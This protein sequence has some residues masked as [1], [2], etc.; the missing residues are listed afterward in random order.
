MEKEM[1]SEENEPRINLLDLSDDVLL[2]ILSNLNSNDLCSLSRTCSRLQRITADKSLWIDV[3]Y[4]LSQSMPPFL[5]LFENL[6]LL[7]NNTRTI[8]LAGKKR[9]RKVPGAFREVYTLTSSSSSEDEEE[10]YVELKFDL[11]I[12]EKNQKEDTDKNLEKCPLEDFPRMLSKVNNNIDKKWFRLHFLNAVANH[13][14]DLNVLKLEY[15]RLFFTT[16]PIVPSWSSLTELSLRGSRLLTKTSGKFGPLYELSVKLPNLVCL[17]LGCCNWVASHCF[18]S[19]SKFSNLRT[20]LLDGCF[21]LGN[22]VAYTSFA[23]CLGFRAIQVMDLRDTQFGDSDLLSFK[24]NAT[25]TKILLGKRIVSS[26]NESK[27]LTRPK[28][29]VAENK[30]ESCS[31]VNEDSAAVQPGCSRSRK[32]KCNNDSTG[33][34]WKR[35]R[36]TQD[37]EDALIIHVDLGLGIRVEHIHEADHVP[38]HDNEPSGIGN[39]V[40]D[41]GIASLGVDGLPALTDLVLAGSGSSITDRSLEALK[42]R[43]GLCYLDVRKTD[44]TEVGLLAFLDKRPDVTVRSNFECKVVE[45]FPA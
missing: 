12:E 23:A 33:R 25:I 44:V 21:N 1:N 28:N 4:T 2:I 20:L 18:M 11:G 22:C 45:N 3:N 6:S 14:P 37:P 10:D 26:E 31:G 36:A 15:M 27:S 13:S 41:L 34:R 16:T 30:E 24:R 5:F 40:T 19:I 32:R 38:L 39:N 29:H 9:S 17:D 8:N 42:K 7:H 35:L 43:V